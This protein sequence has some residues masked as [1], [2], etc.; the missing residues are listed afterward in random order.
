MVPHSMPHTRRE[1]RWLW[2]SGELPQGSVEGGYPGKWSTV[3]SFGL[4]MKT[5][6]LIG[7]VHGKQKAFVSGLYSGNARTNPDTVFLGWAGTLNRDEDVKWVNWAVKP[8]HPKHSLLWMDLSSERW[9]LSLWTSLAHAGF[10]ASHVPANEDS[11]L[12]YTKREK[13]MLFPCHAGVITLGSPKI[14]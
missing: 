11:D 9:V 14:T 5:A 6:C 1:D 12:G 4:K 3:R 8:W 7:L 10:W 13:I 2:I